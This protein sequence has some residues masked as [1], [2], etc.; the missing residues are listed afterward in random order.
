MT[1]KEFFNELRKIDRQHTTPFLSRL[2]AGTS[3]GRIRLKDP[4]MLCPIT[5]VT[6]QGVSFAT[7][8][9]PWKQPP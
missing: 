7:Q 5:A 6:T 9:M 2:G 1:S 4:R 8:E 3:I